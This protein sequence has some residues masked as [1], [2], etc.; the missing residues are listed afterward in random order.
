MV[1]TANTARDRSSATRQAEVFAVAGAVLDPELPVV[2][3]AELGILREATTR[4]QVAVVSI[5][6]TYSGCP[7]ME[8]IRAD[9]VAA[10]NNAG[11][12]EVEIHTVYAP[13]WTTDWIAEAAKSKLAAAGISPPGERRESTGRS[14]LPLLAPAAPSCPRCDSTKVEELSRFGPTACTSLWRCV[15]CAEPFEHM[16]TH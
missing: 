7:A 9:I 1:T 15:S 11:F 4:D 16:K 8:T 13:A 3:I 5:T 6:P 14:M 12:A 2:T 10:L